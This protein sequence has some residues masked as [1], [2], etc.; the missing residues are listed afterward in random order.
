MANSGSFNTGGYDGRC[1]NFSWSVASQ[2]IANN[3]TTINWTLKGAGGNSSVWYQAGNFK[4][5][6]D[7]VQRYFSATRIQLWNGTVVASGSVTLSHDSAGNRSFSAYAEAGI[8]TIAV[9]CSG[10]GSWSLPTI[11][12]KANLTGADNFNDTGNPKITYSNPAGNAVSRLQA[13]ISLTGARDDV[14]YRDISK[15]GTSYTFNLTTAERNTLLNACKNSKT[16]SVKFY[17]KT[18]IGGNTFYS[19]LDRTMTVT[20]ANP[21]FSAS[22]QDTNSTVVGITGNNQQIVRSQSTLQISVTNLS[23]KK[24]ATISSVKCLFNGTTYTGT[25]SGT[26]CTFTLTRPNVSSNTTATVTVT[27][28]RGF[29]TSS[30]LSVQV[31]NW[32]LPS[33]IV[34]MHRHDNYYSNTDITVDGSISSVNNKN[35]MTIKLRYKKISDSTWSDYTTMQDNVAQTF[36]LDNEYEWNVQ[37]LVSDKFGST[38]YNLILSRG[39]PIIYF[40]RLK[41]SVGFN[42]FPTHEVAVEGV[43]PIVLY[44]NDSGSNGSI[45]LNETAANFKYIEIFYKSNNS[46]YSSVKVADPNGKTAVLMSVHP[47]SANTAYFK[48]TTVQ[49]SGTSVSPVSSSELGISASGTSFSTANNI[50]ITKVVGVI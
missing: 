44:D 49:I 14:P 8:Y 5:I 1:L 7:G 29:S 40:D 36:N 17:V 6:I 50:Y 45:T 48:N 38:T 32:V 37:V 12:R 16:L 33:A 42:R 30:N 21:T 39:M 47:N 4:V 23:A 2:S 31:L 24:S 34:T 26:S 19:T 11:P 13:C 43:L 9:N 41:S 10:S 18:V 22:Y 28:S 3:T 25:I 27:D 15:T 20:N 35:A 46:A